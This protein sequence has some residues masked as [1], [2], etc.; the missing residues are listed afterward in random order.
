[1]KKLY[2]IFMAYLAV[3]S[4][5]LLIV[6]FDSTEATIIF[7]ITFIASI[8]LALTF[9]GIVLAIYFEPLYLKIKW[10]FICLSILAVVITAY[11]ISL[12]GRFEFL[13]RMGI[14]AYIPFL[15]VLILGNIFYVQIINIL[16]R[17]KIY[18]DTTWT[19]ILLGNEKVKA[20]ETE[21]VKNASTKLY[22]VP[23][24]IV[25]A[26]TI[27]GT[28]FILLIASFVGIAVAFK[29]FKNAALYL[30]TKAYIITEIIYFGSIVLA[31]V[32]FYVTEH[33]SAL[34]YPIVG[35]IIFKIVYYNALKQKIIHGKTR[36]Y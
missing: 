28:K 18:Y 20:L 17:E 15:V 30:K 11:P 33:Q 32:M 26:G 12:T 29:Y 22:Q 23:F 24:V 34:F 35:F 19:E 6:Q 36:A 5:A 31:A 21:T 4:A 27:T 8:T 2:I 13:E 3:L 10:P 1:M 9:G 14:Y 25:L 7:F 16:K